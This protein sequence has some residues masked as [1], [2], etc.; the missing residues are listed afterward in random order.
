[1]TGLNR[2]ETNAALDGYGP[3]SACTTI[4]NFSAQRVYCREFVS[5]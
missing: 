2:I 4:T 3:L 5:L 1:M